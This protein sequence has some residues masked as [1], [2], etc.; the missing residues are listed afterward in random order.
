MLAIG[1]FLRIPGG[2]GG[3]DKGSGGGRS[4]DGAEDGGG[5]TGS[6]GGVCGQVG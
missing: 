5:S 4:V 3:S 2:N 1:E 6:D